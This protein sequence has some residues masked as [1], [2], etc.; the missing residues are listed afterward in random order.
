MV[1]IDKVYLLAKSC[2]EYSGH[3]TEQVMISRNHPVIFETFTPVVTGIWLGVAEN[4]K[5]CRRMETKTGARCR[6]EMDAGLV[7]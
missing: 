6:V 5:R 1:E 4:A 7:P 3:F 2:D